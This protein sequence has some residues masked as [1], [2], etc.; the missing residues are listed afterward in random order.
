[1]ET[2][3]TAAK[4]GAVRVAE[5][6]RDLSKK[7][8]DSELGGA[9]VT[10][11]SSVTQRVRSTVADPDLVAKVQTGAA[12]LW[13]S[14]LTT[15]SSFWSATKA[16]A[17]EALADAP[18]ATGPPSAK[19][20]RADAP[21]PAPAPAPAERA[22]AAGAGAGAGAAAEPALDDAWLA[23]QVAQMQPP[24]AKPFYDEEDEDETE[25]AP[26][27]AAAKAAPTAAPAAAPGAAAAAKAPEAAPSAA[28]A[29]D[30]DFFGSWGV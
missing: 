5:G 2:L 28:A 1:M 4:E 10:G 11:L 24:G 22:P 9:L 8:A 25:K 21:A 6:S 20:P 3:G 13:T 15:A 18:T 23:A 7:V 29:A 30:E 17:A 26:A 27:A 16:Y 12:S 19:S 14:S